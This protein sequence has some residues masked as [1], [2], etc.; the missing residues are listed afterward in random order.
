MTV[1]LCTSPQLL[2]VVV[3]W[4]CSK[5]GYIN[6]NHAYRPRVQILHKLDHH[7]L[8][9]SM[10]HVFFWGGISFCCADTYD[11]CT[12]MSYWLRSVYHGMQW[13]VMHIVQLHLQMNL[14][15]I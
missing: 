4:G 13:E 6:G 10:C 8:K 5:H 15:T 2:Y 14:Y 12:I 1:G 11:T 3:I 7:N 9:W